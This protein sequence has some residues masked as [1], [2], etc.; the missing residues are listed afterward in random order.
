M[1]RALTVLAAVAALALL[2][3]CGGS[4]NKK[5]IPTDAGASLIRALR[6]ARD[7][8][9]DATKCPQLQ[10]AVQRVQARVASLPASV[11]KDTRDTL[12]NGANH[13]I[14]DARNECQNVQTT[15]TTTTPTTTTPTQTVPTQTQT[16][17]TPTQ[18]TPTQTTPTTPTQ[19]TPPNNGGVS[20]GQTPQVSPPGQGKKGKKQKEGGAG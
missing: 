15:P 9:G 5:T 1:I 8:A 10:T 19:T 3:G 7:L 17:P 20:P 6:Q 18:T 4:S 2:A 12:V 11:D 13:L 14:D 16:T